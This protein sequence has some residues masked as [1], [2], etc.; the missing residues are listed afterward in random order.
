MTV[1]HRSFS[2]PCPPSFAEGLRRVV[3]R[4]RFRLGSDHRSAYTPAMRHPNLRHV[5]AITLGIS[6]TISH[7]EPV[8]FIADHYGRPQTLVAIRGGRHLN[9]A[10]VG[11]GKPT[12]I[13]LSGLG[14]GNFDWR[15]VQPAI[16]NVTRACAYDRAGYGFSEPAAE[17]SD[18][19]NT[20]ADLHA[21]LHAS[22]MK[23]PVILVGHSLGGLYATVYAERYPDEV[24]GM[25]LVDPAFSGQARTI[26]DAVGSKAADAMA[27][28]NVQTLAALDRCIALAQSGR[29]S[30]P[31]EAKSDCLDNPPDPDPDLH[32]ERDREAKTVGFQAMLRSEFQAANVVGRDGQTLDDR[33]SANPAGHLGTMPLVVLTRGNASD[34]PG[35][36]ASEVVKSDAAWREGHDHL[37][38]L[39]THGK[40]TVVPHSGHFIQLD[41]PSAVIAGILEVVDKVRR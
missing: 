29:L 19:D 39:S 6:A 21:L 37:A 38:A 17:P 28:S 25:V 15:K 16:G 14:S 9:M 10:C 4:A 8:S 20:V 26:A 41:Q 7:S 40:N 12:V 2:I 30:L 5:L 22:R 27:A 1:G 31:A 24:S 23:T 35:L 18:V 33:E 34:L 32:R 13:F 3:A 36:S 11:A